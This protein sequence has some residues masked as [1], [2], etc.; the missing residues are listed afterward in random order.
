MDFHSI[1]NYFDLPIM[2]VLQGSDSLFMDR[3][4]YTLTQPWPWIPLYFMLLFM[5]IKNNATLKQILL[6]LGFAILTVSFADIVAN[7]LVKPYFMRWRPTRDPVLKYSID[8][9]QNYRGGKYGFFSA[10]A[11][12][13][14]SI[15][16]FFCLIVRSRL[17][18]IAMMSWSLLNGYTRI[19][20]GVHYPSDVLVGFLWGAI[21]AFASYWCF[22]VF[23]KKFT[24]DHNFISSH[25]T[26]AGYA[27]SD[28]YY[29][30]LTLLLICVFALFRSLFPIN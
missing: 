21:V 7:E 25:Y 16:L 2:Q 28:I 23:N 27:Y 19:Y 3:F 29:V 20:L 26:S 12:N 6:I 17:F 1:T 24:R 13:T 11:T 4:I 18:T 9:F 10:H 22:S 14:M 5:V 8:V 15:A 30:I